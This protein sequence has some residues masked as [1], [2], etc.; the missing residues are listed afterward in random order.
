MHASAEPVTASPEPLNADDAVAS[1]L[2]ALA[3]G[4]AAAAQKPEIIVSAVEITPAHDEAPFTPSAAPSADPSTSDASAALTTT[5]V[6]VFSS[7]GSFVAGAA[8]TPV[9]TST[10]DDTAAELLRPMLRQWLDDNMPR[11]V[12]RALRIELAETVDITPKSGPKS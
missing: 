12:E 7:T 8:L 5:P 4:L 10:L 2:G 11:I 6:S 1:A 9:S 3:A